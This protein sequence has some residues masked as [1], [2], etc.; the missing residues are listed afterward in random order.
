[1]SGET[2]ITSRGNVVALVQVLQSYGVAPEPILAAGNLEPGFVEHS[3]P[4]RGE[5]LDRMICLAVEATGDEAFGLRFA[6]FVQPNSYHALG[7]ALLY[8]S[9]LR[10]FCQRLD[11]YFTVIT[12]MDEVSFE[13]NNFCLA[14]RP[15]FQ[16]SELADKVNSD[17]WAAFIVKSIRQIAGPDYSPS[18]VEL[19]GSPSMFARARYEEF[20]RCPLEYS[21]SEARIYFDP[22]SLDDVLPSSNAE[23]ARQ[24]DLVVADYL[25]QMNQK[26][27][28]AQIHMKMI[29]F[30]PSGLCSRK[31]VAAALNLTVRTMHNKLEKAGTSYRDILEET[32]EQLAQ[33]YLEQGHRSVSEVAYLLGYADVANFSRAFKRWTGFSPRNYLKSREK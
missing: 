16:Y 15:R 2:F 26:D 18:A 20:F 13:E 31:N 27:L 17:A 3:Q 24:N 5:D 25:A 10:S 1:M 11:R 28:P 8:S 33:E 21:H 19:V 23:L 22:A 30:L 14:V 9:T 6:D 4:I 32:R 7:V 12:T 29:E